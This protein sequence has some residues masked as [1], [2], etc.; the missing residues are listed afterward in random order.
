MRMRSQ[1]LNFWAGGNL[2]AFFFFFLGDGPVMN[3]S[4]KV[5][6]FGGYLQ[7]AK[8]YSQHLPPSVIDIM[9]F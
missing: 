9:G 1:R 6:L 2:G 7:S 8:I 5:H 3:A 4:E